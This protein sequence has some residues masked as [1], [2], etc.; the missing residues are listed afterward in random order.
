MLLPQQQEPGPTRRHRDGRAGTGTGHEARVR[1]WQ[2]SGG[3]L[4][5]HL[6]WLRPSCTSMT[7]C[8]HERSVRAD[9]GCILVAAGACLGVVSAACLYRGQQPPR[10]LRIK[11][12]RVV[13]VRESGLF[14]RDAP[15]LPQIGGLQRREDAFRHTI[16]HARQ[17]GHLPRGQLLSGSSGCRPLPSVSGRPPGRA[18]GRWKLPRAKAWMRGWAWHWR[19][20][21]RPS[22]GSP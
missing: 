9:L 20:S 3:R 17:D 11:E 15:A 1:C 18:G 21:R 14:V 7:G 19:D 16:E 13:G 4:S 2:R 12:E 5:A 10:G 6:C 8:P 22:S